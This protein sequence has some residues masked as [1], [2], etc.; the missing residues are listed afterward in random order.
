MIADVSSLDD[1]IFG[2]YIHRKSESLMGIIQNGM[3]VGYFDWNQA[4][5]PTKVRSYVREI[6]MNLVIIH[7][8]VY[9]V[10]ALI[11]PR[12]MHELVNILS[13]EFYE[14]I[15]EVEAFNVNGIIC[16]CHSDVYEG[17]YDHVGVISCLGVCG[18][19]CSGGHS[20]AVP[21]PGVQGEL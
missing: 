16:V 17:C 2:A 6:L 3:Q 1:R 11:V 20:G 18:A 14:C 19:D 10:S 4:A 15:G 21:D 7:A 13:R 5:E 12:V 9:A 8:E